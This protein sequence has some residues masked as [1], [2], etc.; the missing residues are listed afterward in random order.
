MHAIFKPFATA[1]LVALFGSL[2]P[3]GAFAFSDTENHWNQTCIDRL[4]EFNIVSGY[5]DGSFQPDATVTRAEFAILMLNAFPQAEVKQSAIEFTDVAADYWARDAIRAA[6]QRAFFAGYPD[7]T[8]KPTQ[9]IPRVQA[10]AVVTNAAQYR[11]PEEPQAIVRQYYTDAAQIPNYAIEAIATATLGRLA[12]NYPDVGQFRPNDRATR[13]EVT[14]F[15]CQALDFAKTVP[16]AY[17]P[18]ADRFAIVPE[19]GGVGKFSEGLATAILQGRYGYINE[20]GDVAIAPQFETAMTFSEGLAAAS[21]NQT[22]GYI[23]TDGNWAIEPQFS[24]ASSFSDGLAR[25]TL[26][27]TM[28]FIDKT[29]EMAISLTPKLA[30][31]VWVEDTE[32]I[33]IYASDFSDGL[34]KVTVNG[35]RYGFIDTDGNWAIAPQPN[36]VY[37]FSEGL[38]S[39]KIEGK[40]GYIDKTGKIA[41]EPQFVFAY[42]FQENL[43]VVTVGTSLRNYQRGY[44]DKD[45]NWAIEPQFQ[46]AQWFSEG[47]AAV[48]VDDRWKYIDKTGETVI[49]GQFQGIDN[50]S[51]R[52]IHPFSDGLA[53][54]R[55]EDTAG[56]IDKTG[57]FAIAPQYSDATPFHDGFAKVNLG[58]RWVNRVVGYD[59]SASPITERVLAGGKWGYIRLP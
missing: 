39:I 55:M 2:A 40:Y 10:V 44:I 16:I 31:E 5:P 23:D 18:A 56:Y 58:G 9:A 25:V 34:A 43:A 35:N 49:S 48:R 22:W 12:V 53:L 33:S 36:Y 45:G 50:T 11:S 28:G 41:I 14:A 47:L 37:E 8:F 21:E 4:A 52:T 3:S 20:R 51:I 42:Q 29:G 6:T 38:A 13:G 26:D 46:N 27:G 19:M 30:Q 54:V 17:I 24:H 15:L 57:Q 32:A 1:T 7:R 59:G